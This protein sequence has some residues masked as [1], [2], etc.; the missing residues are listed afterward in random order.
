MEKCGSIR[1]TIRIVWK[2]KRRRDMR[3]YKPY[4][5]RYGY[6]RYPRKV[7]FGTAQRMQSNMKNNSNDPGS[8]MLLIF[9]PWL[10]LIILF[11]ICSPK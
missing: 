10:L 7:A 2:Q 4:S 11:L 8:S 9:S 1:Q 6:G 5:R 3:N